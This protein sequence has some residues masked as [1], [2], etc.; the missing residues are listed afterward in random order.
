MPVD[1][2]EANRLLQAPKVV[3][4]AIRWTCG[5][6]GVWRLKVAVG[7]LDGPE[8]LDL[9]GYVARNHSFALLLDN[10]PV[11]RF[12]KHAVHRTLER[13]YTE[14]HKHVFAGEE[15]PEAVYVPADIDPT[16]DINDQFLSFCAECNIALV[17]TYQRAEFQIR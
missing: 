3:S 1:V 8:V 12:T 11:R 7:V 5:P 14:P 6:A 13:V 16:A 10:V 2:V 4:A 15:E 9:R 17:G